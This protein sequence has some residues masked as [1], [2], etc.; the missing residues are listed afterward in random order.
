MQSCS[1]P[2]KAT[3][4]KISIMYLKGCTSWESHVKI[5]SLLG[6]FLIQ[7]LTLTVACSCKKGTTLNPTRHLYW[8]SRPC[9]WPAP[10]GSLMLVP[11]ASLLPSC[12]CQK[13][14]SQGRSFGLCLQSWVNQSFLKC[15]ELSSC[16]Y[17]DIY[18][19][20]LA[21][22]KPTTARSEPL[23]PMEWSN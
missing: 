23:S 11:I 21:C 6:I 2:F 18:P 9:P 20:W 16:I 4:P 13:S 7:I 5:C 19:L 10:S 17:Q 22:R 14:H 1:R 15:W 8:R 12:S 3:S